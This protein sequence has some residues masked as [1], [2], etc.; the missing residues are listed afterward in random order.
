VLVFRQDFAREDSIGSHA[1]CMHVTNVSPL[2]C[3]LPLTA[4][5]VNSVQTLKAKAPLPPPTGHCCLE[6]NTTFW[7]ER[8]PT[9]PPSANKSMSTRRVR[10]GVNGQQPPCHTTS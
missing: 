3:P 8:P 10:A 2:G 9:L 7:S 1:C 4:T 5:T 6:S